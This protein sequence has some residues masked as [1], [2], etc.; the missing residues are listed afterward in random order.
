MLPLR[1][2][3]VFRFR[4]LAFL[5]LAFAMVAAC[6]DSTSLP[7]LSVQPAWQVARL[8][9]GHQVHVVSEHIAC[10]KCHELSGDSVG[11]PSPARCASCH[12]QESTIQHAK[13]EATQRFGDSVKADCTACHAFARPDPGAPAA[14]AT[15]LDGGAPDAAAADAGVPHGDFGARDC[16][17]CHGVKQGDTPA[18]VIHA[19]SQCVSC[20]RPHEDATPKPGAC[21]G[22]HQAIATTHAALGNSPIQVCTTCHQHQHSPA[23]DALETCATC[24]ATQQPIVPAT[25]LF[26]N[27]HVQCVGCHKPH[28]FAK[29]A[30]VPCR[31]CHAAL[32]VLAESMVLAHQQC[33]SCHSPHDVRGSPEKACQGCHANVHPDHP[34]NRRGSQ[35]HRLPRSTP[36]DRTPARLRAEVQWL[37]SS[38]ALGP[39]FS[40][41]ARL[42][43]VPRAARLLAQASGPE[44]M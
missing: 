20:H 13:L 40:P 12:K 4:S 32:H 19:S 2:S 33:T 26:A 31:S 25:A 37:S 23:A 22:C 11:A 18:I 35:L 14:V 21:S 9:R 29:T 3:H 39:G 38:R 41:G 15:V 42:Y 43:A 30:A 28:D 7:G 8:S 36:F 34:E 24:H 5:A 16:V 1:M 17:R 6:S 44:L 10:A 27:G